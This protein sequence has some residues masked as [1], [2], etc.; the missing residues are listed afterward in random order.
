M[1]YKLGQ[2]TH[3]CWKS[4]SC[5]ET[6]LQNRQV[7]KEHSTPL[8]TAPYL[9]TGATVQSAWTCVR[10]MLVGGKDKSARLLRLTES[11]RWFWLQ[12]HC[13]DCLVF[14]PCHG[15]GY[16]QLHQVAQSSIEPGV[17]HLQGWSTQSFPRKSIPVSQQPQSKKLFPD[18]WSKPTLFHFEAISPCPVHYVLLESLAPSF[19]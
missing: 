4:E 18:I 17:E 5:S 12:R 13:E 16:L 15:Q 1:R 9:H 6:I 14:T 7:Q 8:F 2:T 3:I 19:V 11:Q 10:L